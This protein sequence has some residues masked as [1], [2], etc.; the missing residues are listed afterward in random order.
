MED[1]EYP[2]HDR[3]LQL[4]LWTL[5]RFFNQRTLTLLSDTDAGVGQ[6]CDAITLPELFGKITDAIW[7][8]VK[9]PLETGQLTNRK[10]LI[11]SIRRNLQHEHLGQWI[12]LALEDDSG[13]A[14][15]SAKTQAYYHL[16]KLGAEVDKLL[17]SNLGPNSL[18]DYSRA[19]LEETSRRI[20]KVLEAIYSRNPASGGSGAIIILGHPSGEGER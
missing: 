6:D 16:K 14:P 17:A 20:S 11:S 10:P 2:I 12:D 18:D 9:R 3:I 8:E 5:F 7:S 1:V 19:H 13:P 4:Q 15:Q